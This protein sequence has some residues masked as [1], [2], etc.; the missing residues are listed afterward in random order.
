MLSVF[1]WTGSHAVRD[2]GISIGELRA[3]HADVQRQLAASKEKAKQAGLSSEQK[4]RLTA[5]QQRLQKQ[6]TE[7]K[8]SIELSER[9]SGMDAVTYASE[10]RAP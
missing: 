5:D 8:R 6:E 4:F 2:P 9:A 10:G 7:L 1:F 3:K